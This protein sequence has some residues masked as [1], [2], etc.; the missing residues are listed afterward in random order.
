MGEVYRARDA[1]LNREV[2]IKVLPEAVAR[3]PERLARFQREAQLLAALNHPHIGAI[4]GLVEADGVEALVLELVE[5]DTLAERIAGG[6]MP[7]DEALAAARQ[8]GEALEAA[9]EKGIVHRDLKPANVKITPAG[10]VK[11]LDFGLAKALAVDGSAPD[12]TRSP[13]ITAAAT[14]AGV[15]IGTAAYMSPEQA[16]GRPVDKRSDIWSFGVVLYEMLTGRRCFEGETVS[17]V[18]AAVLRQDPDWS[19]LPPDTP[20][21][22]RS[23]LA[24]CL[25][26]DPKKRLRD[27]G[28]AWLAAEPAARPPEAPPAP[29]RSRSLVWAAAVLLAL[30]TGFAAA[31]WSAK[32]APRSAAPAV[33][34][35]IPLP[36]GVQL[37][38]WASPVIGISRD[39][40]TIAFVGVKEGERPGLWV[41]RLDGSGAVAVPDSGSAE[42]PF[43]SPDGQWIGFATDVSSLTMSGRSGALH[44]HSLATRLTQPLGPIP[45]FFG[46]SWADDGSIIVAISTTEGLWRF[47]ADGGKPDTSAESVL[48]KGKAV[49]RSLRWPQ[50]IG[51]KQVL[52]AEENENPWG[53]AAVLDLATRELESFERDVSWA[54]HAGGHLLT[55]RTDRTLLAAPFDAR[56][57]RPAGPA[58]AVL[59]EVAFGCNGAAALA[60]SD[61]GTLVYAKGYIRG[62]GAD[63]ARLVRVDERGAVETLPFEAEPLGRVPL[64]SPDGRFLAVV[65]TD[66]SLGIY[67]LVRQTRGRLALGQTRAQGQSLV[68]SPD[69]ASVVYS[70]TAEGVEGW[71]I[72]RQKVGGNE[73]PATIVAGGEEKYGV[74]WTPDGATLIYTQLGKDTALWALPL[75]GKTPPRRIV[76][77]Q[78][79]G[80]SVSADGRWL[81]YEHQ[82]SES[83]QTYVT[84][85]NGDGPQVPAVP[86]GRFPRFS[87]D[88]RSLYARRGDEL[89]RVRVES[90]GRLDPSTPEV[91][92][93]AAWRGYS[94]AP[95]GKGF[96]AVVDAGD[97]GI[98]RELH[99]VTN[100]FTELEKLSPSAAAR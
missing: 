81:A 7:V 34:S 1:K 8:I 82:D 92:F 28:D 2:A 51:P 14:Q 58:V 37:F 61:T 41:Q 13:T 75:D 79:N 42:G 15:V 19:A 17:D 30:A 68:W 38:G 62:S 44:K 36:A 39:G 66:G 54:R 71:S 90:G 95:D 100:W 21:S 29:T 65:N 67:D 16:R 5:G 47:P 55:S 12:V 77:G 56:R 87:P 6:A 72:Y 78:V 9:H 40:S 43:F 53:G 70:G 11:V 93:K 97:S 89:V 10:S 91:L 4:Y 23:L 26:R 31:R 46:A 25:E 63:L 76:A 59:R 83:W 64:A 52:L 3:D 88:G 86:R 18:L 60:V 94:V 99:L 20:P 48:S 84:A 33:H 45:D 49:R 35:V 85:L 96:Y 73:P 74:A 50:W 32:P 24:R 98:V 22:V 57:L 69:G 80:A 27:I